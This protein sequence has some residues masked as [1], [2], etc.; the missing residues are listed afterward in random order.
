MHWT[1][2]IQI[3]Y[4][5]IPAIVLNPGPGIVLPLSVLLGIYNLFLSCQKH[6]LSN[7]GAMYDQYLFHYNRF[8]IVG[9]NTYTCH[10]HGIHAGNSVW[11]DHNT[12]IPMVAPLPQCPTLIQPAPNIAPINLA[13]FIRKETGL[14]QTNLVPPVSYLPANFAFWV[15]TY[16]GLILPANFALPPAN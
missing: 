11:A 16:P 13:E 3:V 1:I 8:A 9:Y 4:T 2:I 5:T 10:H 6:V 7:K 14:P 12:G 15:T